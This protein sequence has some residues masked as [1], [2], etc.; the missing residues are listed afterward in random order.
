MKKRGAFFYI[1]IAAVLLAAVGLT[2]LFAPGRTPDTP[3]VLLPAAMVQADA[4]EQG[5]EGIPADRQITV[6]P[7]TVQTVIATLHRAD[8]YARTLTVTDFWS[9]GSRART[10]EVWAKG[11][12]LRLR[13]SGERSGS[14]RHILL[15][16]SEKRIWYTD[17]A[18]I[19]VGPADASDADAFQSLITYEKVLDLPQSDILDAGY[20]DHLGQ[21]CIYVRFRSGTLGYIS[22]CYIAPDT[23]LLMGERSYDGDTLIYAMDSSAPDLSTPD[24]SVFAAPEVR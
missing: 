20:T 18:N 9:G 12:N 5:Q 23:G 16:G 10:V 7:E 22:E 6:T 24:E 3:P 19:Y 17:S 8:S 15:T 4:P 21:S 14:L 1:L 11:E 13:I 2:L